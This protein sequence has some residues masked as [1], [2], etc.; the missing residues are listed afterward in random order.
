MSTHNV[1]ALLR[2]HAQEHPD[3][4]ALAMPVGREADGGTKWEWWNYAQLDA[5][6]DEYA[7]GFLATGLKAGDRTLMLMKPNHEFYAVMFGLQK[8][9]ALPVML[10]PGMGVMNLLRCIGQIQPVGIV[11][12]PPVHVVRLFVRRPFAKLQH[13]YTAGR[14]WFWGGSTLPQV[15]AA[16]AGQT[17]EP[18]H[19]DPDDEAAIIFTSGST[20]PAK[21]VS[22][23]HGAFS[24]GVS[25]IREMYGLGHGTK[26]VECFAPFAIYDLAMGSTVIIPEMD[27]SKPATADPVRVVEAIDKHQADTAFASPIVWINTVRHCQEQG[28]KLNSLRQVLAAGA[29]ITADMHRRFRTVLREGAEVHTPYGCT[30]GMPVATVATDLILAETAAMTAQGLGTC[31]G[32]LAPGMEVRF[33]QITDSPMPEWS[34]SLLVPR[35]EIGELVL[36][37]RVVSP[38][39][40]DR[41]DANKMAKIREGDRVLHRMGD[42]GYIDDQ[43]RIWFC[44]RKSHRLRT[45]QG[46]VPAVPVEGVFNEHP[47]VLR[48]ALV[49]VGAPDGETPVLC[50]EL[51]QGEDWTADDQQA[52]LAL[53]DGTKW[54]GTVQHVLRHAAFPVDPRHNS[55]IKREQLKVYAAVQLPHLETAL[56]AK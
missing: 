2:Q 17:V 56:A 34:D 7:A 42:L 8:M 28:I 11:A 50:I 38:E 20:G 52:L 22:L 45:Q 35:G 49:G 36:K 37:G 13:V 16:G 3:T 43:G 18:V 26:V 32:T 44:G 29:P 1:G 6:S 9:G 30:E 31:V 27:L 55:K 39:Y 15:R 40:K 53:A 23:R 19:A 54:Q 41:P 4:P 51:E 21:G 46:M 48:S 24:T 10:D 14:R 33:V 12:I 25:A 5:A 47:K